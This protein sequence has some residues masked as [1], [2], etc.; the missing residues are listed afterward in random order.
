M[1]QYQHLYSTYTLALILEI[2]N[3]AGNF[4]SKHKWW[5]K[6]TRKN[7]HKTRT[8]KYSCERLGV[9]VEP[10]VRFWTSL[11]SR[12]AQ[13]PE[14][15]FQKKRNCFLSFLRSIYNQTYWGQVTMSSSTPKTRSM[16]RSLSCLHKGI[17]KGGQ[18]C[19][20][21]HPSRVCK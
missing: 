18:Q 19:R 21:Y 12:T 16:S 9:G 6:T 13:Y 2:N 10:V 15:K 17:V 4:E 5:S 11:S 14:S 3:Q 20:I 7:S 1:V 8:N